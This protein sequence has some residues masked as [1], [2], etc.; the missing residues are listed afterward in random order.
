MRWPYATF[1][2]GTK[3]EFSET[4]GRGSVWATNGTR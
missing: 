1:Q 2:D 3:L 4:D